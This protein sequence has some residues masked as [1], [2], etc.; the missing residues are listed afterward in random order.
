M[1]LTDSGG[2]QE[3]AA[4]LGK[5]TLVMRNDTERREVLHSGCV[6]LVGVG[7]DAVY[8]AFKALMENRELYR[9]MAIPSDASGDGC[10]S[11]RIADALEI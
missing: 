3:E 9:K 10:A 8:R 4:Y 5:P 7:E 1:I 2:I 6:R 11:V